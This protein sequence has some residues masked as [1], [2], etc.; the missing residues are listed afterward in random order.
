MRSTVDPELR[1]LLDVAIAIQA[2]NPKTDAEMHAI[3]CAAE[4]YVAKFLDRIATTSPHLA[5]ELLDM[6]S[7]LR[8]TRLAF[9]GDSQTASG[10]ASSSSAMKID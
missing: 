8:A 1:S 10:D 7:R 5:T 6:A 4:A 3:A 2:G 9:A